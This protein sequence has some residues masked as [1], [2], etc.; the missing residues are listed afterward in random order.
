MSGEDFLA[1]AKR[2]VQQAGNIASRGFGHTAVVRQKAAGD[3]VTQGDLDV[4]QYVLSELHK[5]YPDHGFDSEERGTEHKD[6]EYVWI[7]DP[8]DGTKYYARGVPL[9]S[10]SLALRR[11]GDLILGVVFSPESGQVFSGGR[12][13]P[14]TL[15][16]QPIHC[17]QTARLEDAMIFAEFPSRDHPPE[18]RRWAL[19]K[20][21]LL[22]G[23]A[24]HVRAIGVGALGLCFCAA[25]GCDAYVNLASGSKDWDLAAGRAILEAAGGQFLE[26]GQSVV[27]GPAILCQQLVT[28]LHLDDGDQGRF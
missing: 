10:V 24:R 25:A 1:A 27:A 28:L 13:Q 15:N 22:M 3:L 5:A 14:A 20:L 16:D 4:E 23:Q 8:I 9:Y 12:G 17:S 7:L 6:A 19:Q 2:I 11:R 26:F 21:G 18:E